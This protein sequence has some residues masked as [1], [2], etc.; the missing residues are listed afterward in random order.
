MKWLLAPPLEDAGLSVGSVSRLSVV[1]FAI[2]LKPEIGCS[3]SALIRVKLARGPDE[4]KPG[5]AVPGLPCRSKPETVYSLQY[6]GV[7]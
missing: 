3:V 1:P 2:G 7:P 5:T 4:E 6:A